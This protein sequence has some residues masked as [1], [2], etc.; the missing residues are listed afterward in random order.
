LREGG[1]CDSKK[2]KKRRER[3]ACM[4]LERRLSKAQDVNLSCINIWLIEDMHKR[5]LRRKFEE[6]TFGGIV[7]FLG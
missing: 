1:W 6:I 5:R 2:G 4:H 3:H 7:L